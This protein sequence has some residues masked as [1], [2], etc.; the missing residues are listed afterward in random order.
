[1]VPILERTDIQTRGEEEADR[2]SDQL[3][4]GVG[5]LPDLSKYRGYFRTVESATIA[6]G[7]PLRLDKRY[8]SS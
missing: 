7:L 1:M 4:V 2:V 3:F 6:L 5:I 8:I